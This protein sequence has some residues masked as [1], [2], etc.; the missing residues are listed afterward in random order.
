MMMRMIPTASLPRTSATTPA[1]S[2]T[3]PITQRIGTKTTPR[4]MAP[5]REPSMVRASSTFTWEI[6][7]PPHLAHRVPSPNRAAPSWRAVE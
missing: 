3:T 2:R 7:L 6:Q 1:T 5:N 4:A